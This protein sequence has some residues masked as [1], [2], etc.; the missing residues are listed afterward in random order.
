MAH[1]LPA[2]LRLDHLDTAFFA[3]N[4]AVFHSFIL[5]TI[6]FIVLDRTEDFGTEKPVFLRLEGSIIDGLW[7][8]HLS[9][10]P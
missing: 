6:T 1:S 4:T 7:F 2:D 8:F 9:M 10:G 5:A 3:D